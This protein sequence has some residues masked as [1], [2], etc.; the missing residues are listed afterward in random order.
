ML[1]ALSFLYLKGLMLQSPNYTTNYLGIIKKKKIT[2]CWLPSPDF[3]IPLL[4]SKTSF[5]GDSAKQQI[6]NQCPSVSRIYLTVKR[7]ILRN[8]SASP[9]VGLGIC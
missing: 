6:G 7:H 8:C 4:E 9:G 3:L 2:N 1:S 5:L